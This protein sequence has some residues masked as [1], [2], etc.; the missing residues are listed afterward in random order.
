MISEKELLYFSYKNK[1][2]TS[3]GKMLLPPEIYKGYLMFKGG[4]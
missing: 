4:Q 2:E 1:K 3:L